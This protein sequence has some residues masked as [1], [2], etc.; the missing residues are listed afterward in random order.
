MQNRR[1]TLWAVREECHLSDVCDPVV[2]RHV[3]RTHAKATARSQDLAER[4]AR[5]IFGEP[6]VRLDGPDRTVVEVSG[7]LMYSYQIIPLELE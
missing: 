4:A 3:F 1:T 5:E 6:E 2:V 7:E